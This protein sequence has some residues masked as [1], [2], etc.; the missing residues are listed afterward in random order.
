MK[1]LAEAVRVLI[2]LLAA[3]V[4]AA[5]TFVGYGATVTW[6]SGEAALWPAIQLTMSLWSPAV[7]VALAHAVVLGLPAF[8][9]LRWRGW[10]RWWVSLVCGF[11]IGGLP[12]AIYFSPF[13]N[14]ASFSQVDDKVLVQDGVTTLAGWIDYAESIGGL[15][16]LGMA[17]GLAAWLTW[18]W[19]GRVFGGA[20]VAR[21]G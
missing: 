16:L 8:L 17:G 7:A 11:A 18:Y 9:V 15:G 20:K 10:T 3:A 4:T 2:A 21:A 13:D 1:L 5:T 19:L 14:A 6:C 12:F